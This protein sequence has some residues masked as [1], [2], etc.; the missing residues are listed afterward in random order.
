MTYYG[1]GV[2]HWYDSFRFQPTCGVPVPENAFTALRKPNTQ[3]MQIPGRTEA[4]GKT[5][6]IPT[7]AFLKNKSKLFPI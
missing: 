7:R 1:D 4:R 5:L 2:N 6:K 3:I